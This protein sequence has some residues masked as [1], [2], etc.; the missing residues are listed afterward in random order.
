MTQTQEGPAGQVP[1]RTAPP[2]VR[3]QGLTKRFGAVT[4]VDDLDLTVRSGEIVAF[5]GPNGAGQTS[6]IDMM[7]GLSRPDGGTV[8]VFGGTPRAAVAHGMISAVMQ[9]GCLLKDL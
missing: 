6:N 7:L 1:V 2:A 4:A 5:L 8:E 3:L 9:T